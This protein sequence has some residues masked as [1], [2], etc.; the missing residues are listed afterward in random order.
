[1]SLL[2]NMVSSGSEFPG[3][4]EYEALY[5]AT[6]A[7]L[8]HRD[9]RVVAMGPACQASLDR[10]GFELRDGMLTSRSEDS[11]RWIEHVIRHACERFVVSSKPVI[12]RIASGAAGSCTYLKFSACEH[13]TPGVQDNISAGPVQMQVRSTVDLDWLDVNLIARTFDLSERERQLLM[14]LLSGRSMTQHAQTLGLSIATVRVQAKGIYR[15]FGVR[16]QHQVVAVA[17]AVGR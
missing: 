16:G 17:V 14:S 13:S 4:I 10:V 6:D 11:S 5:C 2:R 12:V 3:S 9:R 8:V 7:L 15:K 1:M